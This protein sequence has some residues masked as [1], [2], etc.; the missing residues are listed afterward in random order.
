MKKR[1]SSGKQKNEHNPWG[2]SILIN[3]DIRF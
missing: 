3:L 2:L 1:I